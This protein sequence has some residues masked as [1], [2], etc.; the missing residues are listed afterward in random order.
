[1]RVRDKSEEQK[2]MGADT[3]DSGNWWVYTKMAK[4]FELYVKFSP[5]ITLRISKTP[6]NRWVCSKKEKAKIKSFR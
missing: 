6:S 4:R 3:V 2:E 5:Q 1:M